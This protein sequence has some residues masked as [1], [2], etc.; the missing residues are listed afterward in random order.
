MRIRGYWKL[1][2][3]LLAAGGIAMANLDTMPKYPTQVN[4]P[5]A[6]SWLAFGSAFAMLLLWFW[7]VA[8]VTE[9]TSKHKSL[10]RIALYPLTAIVGSAA[11]LAPLLLA[12]LVLGF[13]RLTLVCEQN[14]QGF[15]NVLS[16]FTW[17]IGTGWSL[18]ASIA[19]VAATAMVAR[20]SGARDA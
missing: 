14:A 17:H 11:F 13:C 10:V 6:V 18:L 16:V 19:L 1:M 7:L 5:P 15:F 4:W 2:L 20:A 12:M 9:W 8:Q 3:A